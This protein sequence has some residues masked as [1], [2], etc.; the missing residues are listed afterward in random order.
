[1]PLVGMPRRYLLLPDLALTLVVILRATNSV[2]GALAE[3]TNGNVTLRRGLEGR[4][5][6]GARNELH[7]DENEYIGQERGGRQASVVMKF[8]LRRRT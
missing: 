5:I 7:H 3:P 4:N 1:V 2:A 8:A 6:L